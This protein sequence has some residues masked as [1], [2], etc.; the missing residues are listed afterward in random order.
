MAL[1][2]LILKF[3]NYKIRTKIKCA[4]TTVNFYYKKINFYLNKKFS[5]KVET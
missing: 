1:I 3:F 4:I 2:F 5:N